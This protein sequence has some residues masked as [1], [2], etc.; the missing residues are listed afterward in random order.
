MRS[1]AN[2]GILRLWD[3]RSGSCERTWSGH[4]DAI[5]DFCIDGKVVCTCSED[6]T[7]RVFASERQ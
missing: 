1:G 4:T 5:L 6:G 3:G 7:A 2:D